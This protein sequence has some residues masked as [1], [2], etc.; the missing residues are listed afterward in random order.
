MFLVL[1]IA[2]VCLTPPVPGPV[3]AGYAPTG[4]FSGHWGVDFAAPMGESVAAPVGGRITFAGSV[5]GMR[6]ITIEPVPGYKVSVSYLSAIEVS[7]GDNVSRGTSIGR[8]GSPHGAPGVHMSVRVVDRYVDP[9]GLL[10]CTETDITRALRLVT[11][12]QPRPRRR[13]VDLS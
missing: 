2:A 10:G 13:L 12:P 11:P 1:A 4:T 7:T 5:A 9:A 3:I 6:T 8:A